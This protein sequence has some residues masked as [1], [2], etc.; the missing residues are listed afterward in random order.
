MAPLVVRLMG[1]AGLLV[2]RLSGD[3]G[4][5]DRNGLI[6]TSALDLVGEVWPG[7]PRLRELMPAV[8]E[9]VKGVFVS[10]RER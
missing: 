2:P 9:G 5:L 8:R 7:K 6:D 1:D 10:D 3:D 4:L